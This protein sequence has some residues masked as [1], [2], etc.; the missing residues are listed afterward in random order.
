MGWFISH[1]QPKGN[2]P[3]SAGQADQ[4]PP[5]KKIKG[6]PSASFLL[7]KPLIVKE[8]HSVARKEALSPKNGVPP[9]RGAAKI[10]FQQ[11]MMSKDGGSFEG[12]VLRLA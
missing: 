9:K 3:R 2:L 12:T 8:H 1:W 6:L 11:N 7:G 4:P 5:L 10:G